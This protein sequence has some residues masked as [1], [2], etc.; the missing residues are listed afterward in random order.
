MFELTC[1]S[2]GNGAVIPKKY[3]HHTVRGGAN[4]SPGFHWSDPPL[5]T[6]S[7]ALSIV[8]PHP[9]AKNWVHWLV[10]N[11]PFRDRILKEGGSRKEDIPAPAKELYNTYGELGYGGPAPPP[12]SGPHP[13]IATVYA[14][15]EES[16][17]LGPRTTLNEFLRA[18]EGKVIAEATTR[19]VY[20]IP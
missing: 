14:L 2:Y 20:E 17:A 15:N 11:I 7:F 8:D 19:G 4:V 12:G 5:N 9:V 13:Y 10:I 3:A 16:L 6:K 18:L 1:S